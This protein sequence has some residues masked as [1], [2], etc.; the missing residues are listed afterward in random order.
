MFLAR[1]KVTP[2]VYTSLRFVA[3]YVSGFNHNFNALNFHAYRLCVGNI[4][5]PKMSANRLSQ[6]RGCGALEITISIEASRRPVGFL[7][8]PAKFVRREILIL[9]GLTFPV[10]SC[11]EH[12]R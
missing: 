10:V 2:D 9:N 7:R 4:F 8:L 1:E 5:F 6:S 3:V 11:D 12:F